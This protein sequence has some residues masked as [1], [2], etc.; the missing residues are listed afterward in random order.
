[1]FAYMWLPF[2]LD[3]REFCRMKSTSLPIPEKIRII[4]VVYNLVNWN[5]AVITY[6]NIHTNKI[7]QNPTPNSA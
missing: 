5:K 3:L 4:Y 2:H 7:Q 6:N 1:M